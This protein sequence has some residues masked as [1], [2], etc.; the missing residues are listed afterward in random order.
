MRQETSAINNTEAALLFK[1]DSG[2]ISKFFNAIK[3]RIEVTRH[4]AAVKY[5]DM[6][7]MVV[8]IIVYDEALLSHL[9]KQLT[10]SLKD[11]SNSYDTTIIL[12]RT[13]KDDIDWTDDRRLIMQENGDTSMPIAVV[14]GVEGRLSGYDATTNTY[15]YGT[16]RTL[17]E[18]LVR[19]GHIFFK[20]FYHAL[21]RK[22]E[23]AFV[24]GACVGV[25]GKGALLCARGNRGKSTLAVLSLL[26]GFE[27]VSDDY[28]V[29]EKKNGGMT[30]SPIYSIITLSPTM[31]DRMF[32]RLEGTRFVSNNWNKSKY[33]IN[34]SNL[35]DRFRAGYPVRVCLFPE[36]VDEPEPSVIRCDAMTKGKAITQMAHSTVSQMGDHT[37]R[38]NIVKMTGMLKDMDFYQIRLCPDIYRNVECLRNFLDSLDRQ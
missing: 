34:I 38:K 20:Q 7:A 25:N 29:I 5:I 10:F 1:W 33:I 15:F 36:I 4:R 8:R 26:E 14:D 18:D 3:A 9:Y 2:R 12:W 13:A 32:D 21:L 30:A 17:S 19:E 27:Y 37:N 35:H 28:L 31:Y 11:H 24:H 6:H 23:S 22:T 16:S